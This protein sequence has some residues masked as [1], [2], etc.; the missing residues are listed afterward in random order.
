M[1]SCSASCLKKLE[2]A[3]AAALQR[4]ST[5]QQQC[6]AALLASQWAPNGLT[7]AA[8]QAGGERGQSSAGKPMDLSAWLL[9][10]L[11]VQRIANK[12]GFPMLPALCRAAASA[13][14]AGCSEAAAGRGGASAPAGCAA[15]RQ[16][17]AAGAAG[18]SNPVQSVGL[19]RDGAPHEEG[20]GAQAPHQSHFSPVAHTLPCALRGCSQRC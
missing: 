14:S 15:G 4:S 7:G 18:Y 3:C 9:R 2:T 17:Q 20:R 5:A 6:N 10:A 11:T 19:Q 16:Q 12:A 8:C 1:T 13:D